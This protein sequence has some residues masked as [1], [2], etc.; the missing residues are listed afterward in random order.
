MRVTGYRRMSQRLW[1]GLLALSAACAMGVFATGTA[2]ATPVAAHRCSGTSYTWTGNDDGASW[3]D[4]KNWDPN[5]DPGS[6]SADS[7]DIPIEANITGA[8]AVT[9]QNFT[10]DS[11]AGSDGTLV[12]GPL[13]V[14][15]HFE[16][17]G[18]SLGATVNIPAGATGTIAGPANVKG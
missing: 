11:S 7:V 6:C 12:G 2:S 4:A 9:L 1:T 8:P 14:T 10:T 18:S 13:T 3:G 15:G 16:W 17:D 5:G